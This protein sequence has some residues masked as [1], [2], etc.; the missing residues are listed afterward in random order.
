LADATALNVNSSFSLAAWVKLS[1]SGQDNAVYDSG[2]QSE[3]WFVQIESGG[4][5]DFVERNIADNLSN[6]VLTPNVWHHIAIVKSGDSGTN[7][8]LYLNGVADGTASV[9]SVAAPSGEKRIGNWTENNDQVFNG[10]ID[11]VRLYSR[12][13]GAGEVAALYAAGATERRAA[14]EL[15]MIGYWSFDDATGTKA[16]DFSGNGSIGTLT[17][18]DASTDWVVG[19]RGKALDFDGSDDYV[20]AVN[21]TSITSAQTSVSLWVKV[22]AYPQANP[23][24]IEIQDGSSSAQIIRDGTSGQWVTKHSQFQSGFNGTQWGVPVVGTWQHIVVVWD[25]VGNT[26][27]FYLNGVAQDGTANGNIGIGNQANAVYIG[28]RSDLNATTFFDGIIDEV[29]IYNRALSLSEV[30]ALYQLSSAKLQASQNSRLTSGL[31]GLWSFNGSDMVGTTALDR[32]GQGTNGTLTGGARV[33]AGKVGQGVRLDGVDDRVVIPHSSA[34]AGGTGSQTFSM[35]AYIDS[36]PDASSVTL[37]SKMYSLA[38]S[39]ISYSMFIGAD[40]AFYFQTT[41]GANFKLYTAATTPFT[42]REWH[43]IA[44][45]HTWGSGASS[46]LYVDGALVNG[47]WTT[48]TGDDTYTDQSVGIELG[49]LNHSNTLYEHWL[50]G[51]VD[52]FRIYNRMLT[53]AEIRSLYL[54]GR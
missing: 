20:S 11:E 13:L 31:V 37:M 25:S 19:K 10:S 38:S 16:T 3:R 4:K 26:T 30:S 40:T 29:R 41:N 49:R 46:K 35:W 14:P 22:A 52:E 9:G 48:G 50:K 47:S 27:Q 17:N 6:T 7:L 44:F 51:V 34:I 54:L 42:A 36:F 53:A 1:T 43:H 8:T 18:M 24:L 39:E 5:I 33:D 2:T 12:A 45:Q 15:G 28:S 21:S 32:S 23:R